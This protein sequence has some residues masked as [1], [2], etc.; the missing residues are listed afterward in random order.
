[1]D[2]FCF[3]LPRLRVGVGWA[4]KPPVVRS[5]RGVRPVRNVFSGSAD[6]RQGSVTD[7]NSVRSSPKPPPNS[8]DSC[9]VAWPKSLFRLGHTLSLRDSSAVGRNAAGGSADLP[10]SPRLW[11]IALRASVLHPTCLDRSAARAN[12]L[13][14]TDV[15]PQKVAKRQ[16][17]AGYRTPKRSMDSNKNKVLVIAIQF[18]IFRLSRNACLSVDFRG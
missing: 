9:S 16:C 12:I 15:V 7:V 17:G 11:R 3:R 13:R 10:I 6:R 8:P 5:G 1:M 18:P 4:H 2:L 14:R